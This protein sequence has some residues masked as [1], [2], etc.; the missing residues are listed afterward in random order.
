M[1][2]KFRGEFH[3]PLSRNSCG[4]TQNGYVSNNEFLIMCAGK[5]YRNYV[6][7][8]TERDTWKNRTLSCYILRQRFGLWTCLQVK[9]LAIFLVLLEV[10]LK[11]IQ[12]H[13]SLQKPKVACV[14][15]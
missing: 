4:K 15:V 10:I 7:E 9:L 14:V 5:F 3:R 11:E 6:V 13:A 12:G 1:A 8:N 2:S